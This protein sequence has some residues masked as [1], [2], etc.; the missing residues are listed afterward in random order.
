AIAASRA[1]TQFIGNMSHELRTPLNAIIG[2][3]EMLKGQILGPLGKP[4]YIAYAS[5]I[6]ASGV[7]L[8]DALNSIL[9]IA[10]IDGGRY[11]LEE[12]VVPLEEAIAAA[13]GAVAEVAQRK[14][15]A[16]ET[17]LDGVPAALR[18]DAGAI[19]HILFNL[20]SNAVKFTGAEGRV[21]LSGSVDA[22]GDCLLAVADNG[23]GIP[24]D[25]L[26]KVVRPFHQADASRPRK[27]EGVGLG[28]SLA[29]GLM[30]LHGGSLAI[31]SV[32]DAGATV[33]LRF[34]AARVLAAEP[35]RS[36][37]ALAP[38]G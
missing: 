26:D 7:R 2:F 10:R 27:Y 6:H 19:R 4:A 8:R 11:Q 36:A 33:T 34:P 32:P 35:K 37:A 25:Q 30:E 24:P 12:T 22:A 9:D 14:G 13:L 28:L 21:V 29:A 16:I 1:K 3:S 17:R 18:A 20:L 23:I 31:A 38:G 5:D 15:T